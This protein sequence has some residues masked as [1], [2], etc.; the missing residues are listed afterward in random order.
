MTAVALLTGLLGPLGPTPARADDPVCTKVTIVGV[1]GSS[2]D[3]V[4]PHNMGRTADPAAADLLVSHHGHS[5]SDNSATSL[6]YP[7]LAAT[8][9]VW[10]LDPREPGRITWWDSI[11]QGADT[12]ADFVEDTYARCPATKIGLVGYS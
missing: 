9:Y 8:S 1:R 6:Y 5:R 2:E 7:A 11:R 4:G 3:C 10:E 12:L